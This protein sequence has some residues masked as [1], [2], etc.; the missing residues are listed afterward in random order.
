[1]DLP[2]FYITAGNHPDPDV[3]TRLRHRI[4]LGI[5][6]AISLNGFDLYDVSKALVLQC[7]FCALFVSLCWPVSFNPR[8]FLPPPPDY[9]FPPCYNA[10]NIAYKCLADSFCWHAIPTHRFSI[11]FQFLGATGQCVPFIIQKLENQL[12]SHFCKLWYLESDSNLPFTEITLVIFQFTLSVH[13]QFLWCLLGFFSVGSLIFRKAT[14][15]K[16]VAVSTAL[17]WLNSSLLC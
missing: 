14:A 8:L 10:F 4:F 15:K 11:A 5:A 13:C 7:D 1:M 2:C 6:L 9:Y 17:T 16:P 3:F 12:L